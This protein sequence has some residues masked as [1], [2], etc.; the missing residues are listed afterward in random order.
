MQIQEPIQAQMIAEIAREVVARLR[1]QL[2]Q[3]A[4]PATSGAAARDGVFSTVDE[5]A[6]AAFEAQ[7]KVA[8]MSLEERG[9][10][11]DIIRRICTDRAE[12]LGRMELE[13]TKV[14][15]L[16]H[17]ILKLINM[18]LVLGVEAMPTAIVPGCASLSTRP[19][20]SSA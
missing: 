12:E 8:A 6:N 19:G 7:R 11:I 14:G 13:E 18:R 1:V 3:P 9:R 5:A 15:R 16:D 2:Q 17:K 20:A 4:T 10:M